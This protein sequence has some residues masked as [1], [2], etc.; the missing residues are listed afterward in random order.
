[1]PGALLIIC[2]DVNDTLDYKLKTQNL[3]EYGNLRVRLQNV[4]QYPV[5]VEITNAKGE[6]IASEYSGRKWSD[7][8]Q[9]IVTQSF[10]LRVIYD[11][12]KNKVWDT[13]SYLEKLQPEEVV[14]YPTAIDVVY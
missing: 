13:G 5:I 2:K 12:N 9:F 11:E 14:Y 4:R 3:S 6:L 10:T 7:W 1:M 8:F